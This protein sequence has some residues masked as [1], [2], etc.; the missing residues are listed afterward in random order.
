MTILVNSCDAYADCWEPFFSLMKIYWADC[1]YDI[2]LNSETKTYSDDSLKIMHFNNINAK[3]Y[4]KRMRENLLRIKTPYVLLLL[5]DFFLREQV[6]S[7]RIEE[8]VSWLK[9]DKDIAVFSFANVKD[10]YNQTSK[11]YKG[12]ELRPRVGE[13]KLNLQAGI[14]DRKK[15]MRYTKSHENPWEFE[16]IGSMRTFNGKDKF[17]VI[18]DE[19]KSPIQYGKQDG[20]TWGIVRGK[21]F[22]EDVHPLFE[23]HN[24][25]VDY[26]QRGVYQGENKQVV[27][28]GGWWRTLKSLGILWWL[29]I[30][31]YRIKRAVKR[32]F[33][34]PVEVDYY[35]YLRNR[36][37]TK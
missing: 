10:I 36:N 25:C 26:A 18:S 12:F 30:I 20:L 14:W 37:L 1:P 27:I 21:W 28:R 15:L 24:I 33:G 3:T 5:D 22:I 4:G 23:K 31:C 34:L 17:Y 6:D 7:S 9:K 16:T 32:K 35:A 19:K 11:E 2:V 8:I 29:R 13:Y